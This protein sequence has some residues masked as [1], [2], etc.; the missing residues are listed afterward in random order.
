MKEAELGALLHDIGKI[1][2]A[3]AI[4][5]KPAR[6]TDDEY[7]EVKSHCEIGYDLLSNL[8]HFDAIASIVRCHH[9]HFDGTGYPRRLRGEEIPIAA[10]IVSVVEAVEAMVSDRPYRK[11]LDAEGVLAELARG[12]GS[13][14]DPDVVEIFS[15]MLTQDRKHLVMRNSALEVALARS[16]IA[17]LVDENDGGTGPTV[18]GISATFRSA[19]QPIFVLD[20]ELNIVSLNPAAERLVGRQEVELQG[21]GW[22]TLAVNPPAAASFGESRNLRLVPSDGI[23]VDLRITVSSCVQTAQTTGWSSAMRAPG[24]TWRPSKPRPSIPSR[25][26]RRAPS[27]SAGPP[28]R[29]TLGGHRWR[30]FFL[31]STPWR[32]SMTPSG[33]RWATPRCRRWPRS[34]FPSCARTTSRPAGATTN[35]RS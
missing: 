30:W 29:C 11:G 2:V 18:R 20:T 33:A 5:N 22:G 16:P 32:R 19:S 3:E 13:Q 23:D 21:Q 7:E 25:G 12:A 34:S 10:R 31:T 17:E 4:L 24:R 14:W 9:E 35:S 26:S 1:G 8:P 28:S 15:G 27:W 6:L